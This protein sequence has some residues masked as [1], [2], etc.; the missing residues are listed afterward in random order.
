MNFPWS[1]SEGSSAMACW[2]SLSARLILP[3]AS[4]I[5]ACQMSGRSSKGSYVWIEA[6]RVAAA[7][8]RS[9]MTCL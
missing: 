6:M 4:A 2:M 8:G 7:C 9:A 5:S 1:P 3:S